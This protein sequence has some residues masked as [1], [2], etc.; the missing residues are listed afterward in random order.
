M[1]HVVI[2]QPYC[3]GRMKAARTIN[4]KSSHHEGKKIFFFFF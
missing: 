2:S 3:A 1:H 4:P